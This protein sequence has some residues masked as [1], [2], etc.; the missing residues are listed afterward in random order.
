MSSIACGE[1]FTSSGIQAAT[2]K[3]L[4]TAQV[5]SG[6]AMPHALITHKATAQTRLAML[7]RPIAHSRRYGAGKT[8]C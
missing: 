3:P 5:I 7:I 6:N 4:M 2:A 1:R 8:I